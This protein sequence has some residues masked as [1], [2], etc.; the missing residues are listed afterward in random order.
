MQWKL[1]FLR[2][3]LNPSLLK[4]AIHFKTLIF[5][6]TRKSISAWIQWWPKYGHVFVIQCLRHYRH[7]DIVISTARKQSNKYYLVFFFNISTIFFCFGVWLGTPVSKYDRSLFFAKCD[8]RRSSQ[9]S[10]H[11]RRYAGGWKVY[12]R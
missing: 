2:K 3:N 8:R 6:N 7:K 9:F 1:V 12:Q 5:V 11:N 10:Q 4:Q